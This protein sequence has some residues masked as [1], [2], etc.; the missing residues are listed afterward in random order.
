MECALENVD[1]K[2]LYDTGAQ[3]P[4]LSNSPL[5][6]NQM[7]VPIRIISELLYQDE[8]TVETAMDTNIPCVGWCLIKF[9]LSSLSNDIFLQVPF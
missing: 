7:N 9:Q 3:V 8:L 1:A 4:I 5:K 2:L 6:E